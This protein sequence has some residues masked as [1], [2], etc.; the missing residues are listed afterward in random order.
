[1]IDIDMIKKNTV[2]IFFNYICNA[3]NKTIQKKTN[4]I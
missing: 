1:M 4:T 2:V 3:N